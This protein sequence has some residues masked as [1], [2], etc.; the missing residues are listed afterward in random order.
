[1]LLAGDP[2]DIHEQYVWRFLRPQKIDL[3][4]RKPWRQSTDPEFVPKA[5]A[6]SP[7]GATNAA[8]GWSSAPS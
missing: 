2:V 1:M 4:G 3:S 8:G 5:P 6:T 7:A